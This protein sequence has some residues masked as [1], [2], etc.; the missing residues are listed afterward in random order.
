MIGIFTFVIPKVVFL[1]KD[2]GKSLPLPTQILI[3]VSKLFT[4]YWYIGLFL[5]LATFFSVRGYLRTPGGRKR[6]DRFLLHMPV[7]GPLFRMVAISRFASTFSSLL[8]SGVPILVSLDIVKNVLNNRVLSEVIESVRT[9]ISEGDSIAEPLKRSGEF[10]P[11]VTHMIAI[12]EKTGELE[13]MLNSIADAYEIE[14]EQ[15]TDTLTSLLAPVVILLMG[16]TVFLVA[17]ALLLPMMNISSMI[18]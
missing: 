5:V 16:G 8:A 7:F 11:L 3:G 18:R 1:Y 4:S 13:R 10:P 17:I 14:V 15:A 6:F 12:G 2:M 9:N